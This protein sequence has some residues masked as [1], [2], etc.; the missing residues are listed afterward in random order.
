[1]AVLPVHISQEDVTNPRY[2]SCRLYVFDLNSRPITEIIIGW[3]VDLQ[4]DVFLLLYLS[5]SRYT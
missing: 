4:R 5:D 1:M 2:I 3:Q